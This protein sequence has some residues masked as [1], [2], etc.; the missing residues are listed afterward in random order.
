MSSFFLSFD[1]SE[2]DGS[3]VPPS[4]RS[5]GNNTSLVEYQ[6]HQPLRSS[7]LPSP[8]LQ[9][10]GHTGSVYALSYSPSGDTLCSASF[11]TTCLLWNH[12]DPAYANFNVLQHH[13]NAVLDCQWLEEELLVTCSADKTILVWDTNTGQRTRK[14][15]EHTGIVNAVST[16]VHTPA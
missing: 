1:V 3:N 14:W 12:R 5:R 13:K 6:T 7:S 9:L 10:S 2:H 11:D 8:T 16:N 15:T 4:K